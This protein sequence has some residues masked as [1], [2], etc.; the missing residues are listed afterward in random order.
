MSINIWEECSGT[1]HLRSLDHKVFRVV[2]AQHISSTRKLVDSEKEHEILEILIERTKPHLSQASEFKGLHYLL[3]TP[4]RYPP[5][6]HGSRF[7]KTYEP[8]LWYG[9]LELETA[10]RRLPIIVFIFYKEPPRI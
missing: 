8:S 6:R 5:L 2:E 7:G 4:F 1:E 9:S 10:L 3:F